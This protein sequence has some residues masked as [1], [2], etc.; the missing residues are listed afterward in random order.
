MEASTF[1][2]LCSIAY[3]K[4]GITLGPTLPAFLTPTLLQVLVER[5]G[6]APIGEPAA[7]LEAALAGAGS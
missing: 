3:E 7:D 4:A 5:F 2:R 6:I 1:R